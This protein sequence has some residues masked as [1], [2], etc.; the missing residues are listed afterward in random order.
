MTSAASEPEVFVP[1][2]APQDLWAA[3]WR[4]S[5]GPEGDSPIKSIEMIVKSI[6]SLAPNPVAV[7]GRGTGGGA[8]LGGVGTGEREAG[9]ERE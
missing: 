2:T 7:S 8:G 3:G 1:G 6:L 9:Q 5:F 4:I